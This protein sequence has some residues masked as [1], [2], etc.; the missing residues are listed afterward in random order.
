MTV[1]VSD[2]DSSPWCTGTFAS[3]CTY[4]A[5]NAVRRAAEG[6]RERVL[7]IAGDMLEVD[8]ADLNIEDGVVFAEGAPGHERV[9]CRRRQRGNLGA[10]R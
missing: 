5:G 10:R 2:T 7:E 1:D 4:I 3:R 6:V 9:R 8:P